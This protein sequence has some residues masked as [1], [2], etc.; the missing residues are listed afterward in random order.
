MIITTAAKVDLARA[1]ASEIAI[2]LI[3]HISV[4]TG[5]LSAGVPRTPLPTETTLV[6][7]TLKKSVT[8]I[9]RTANKNVYEIELGVLECNGQAISEMGVWSGATLIAIDTFTSKNKDANTVQT[10]RYEEEF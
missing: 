5:G 4:G 3:T 2:P 9:G 7:E 1:R 6:A 8:Y 10:Y